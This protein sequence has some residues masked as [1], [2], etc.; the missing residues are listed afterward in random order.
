MC[1]MCKDVYS[2]VQYNN[3]SRRSASDRSNLAMYLAIA[4]C[5]LLFIKETD[6]F[7]VEAVQ[8]VVMDR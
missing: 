3:Q 4:V 1:V 6:G 8:G 5:V 7:R 2:C